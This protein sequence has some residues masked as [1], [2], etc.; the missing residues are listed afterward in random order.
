MGTPT[1]W[2]FRSSAMS[3]FDVHI[4]RIPTRLSQQPEKGSLRRARTNLPSDSAL[5]PVFITPSKGEPGLA[6]QQTS[7][8]PAFHPERKTI[9]LANV[10]PFLAR[11]RFNVSQDFPGAEESAVDPEGKGG[12]WWKE[13]KKWGLRPL[14]HSIT[15]PRWLFHGLFGTWNVAHARRAG[16]EQVSRDEFLLVI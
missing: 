12:C 14:F 2:L 1:P 7:D 13:A 5:P 4:S 6:F 15:S 16:W 10:S 9:G 3:I 11:R 8:N